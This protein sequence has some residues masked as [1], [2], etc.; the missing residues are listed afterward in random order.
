M[1]RRKRAADPG[2]IDEVTTGEI[3]GAAWAIETVILYA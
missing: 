2:Y 3:N 1:R